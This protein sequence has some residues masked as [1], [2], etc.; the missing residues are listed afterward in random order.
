VRLPRAIGNP[1]QQFAGCQVSGKRNKK[2][3][4]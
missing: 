3:E 1:K 4:T 2:A